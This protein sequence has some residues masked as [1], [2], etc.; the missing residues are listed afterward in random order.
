MG[1]V[2]IRPANVRDVQA[3]YGHPP[4]RSMKAYAA[5]LDDKTIGVAGLYYFPDHL[6]AFSNI[7]PEYR[8]LKVGMGKLALK[9]LEMLEE[10]K[11][12]VF[13]VADPEIK[14]SGDNLLKYGLD[15]YTLNDVGEIYVW[16]PKH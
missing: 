2:K 3:V 6:L 14:G 10:S 11:V 1:S 15:Y 7:L 12:P 13:A 5:T 16:Q 4:K 9:L 8:H